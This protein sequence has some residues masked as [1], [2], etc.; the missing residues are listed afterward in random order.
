MHDAEPV[1]L[2]DDAGKAVSVSPRFPS[3]LSLRTVASCSRINNQ[4]MESRSTARRHAEREFRHSWLLDAAEATFLEHGFAGASV[5]DIAARAEVALGTLYKVFPSKEELF[6]QVMERRMG[7]FLDSVRSASS[8]GS[9]AQRLESLVHATFRHF[10]EQNAAFRL[11]LAVT[12]GLPWLIRSQ[13]GAA[14]A[15]R[16]GELV[17]EVE[18]L[19]RGALP[20]P[21]RQL[22]RNT[23][24]AFVGTLNASVGD[25]IE[26][27]DGRPA[28]EVAALTWKILRRLLSS[29]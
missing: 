17:S 14:A 28:N 18:A 12:H 29:S 26:R 1:V 15:A 25:W 16:Y 8:A 4:K 2:L 5:D 19:C 9:P 10:A 13:L 3:T 24:L 20:A 6:A 22:A 23:A 27:A 21:R 7:R 11:Y